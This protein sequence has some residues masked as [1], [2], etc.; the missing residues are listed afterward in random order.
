EFKNILDPVN[1]NTLINEVN[2]KEDLYWGP[3][4]NDA[5]DFYVIPNEAYSAFGDFEFFSNKIVTIAPQTGFHRLHGVLLCS[6][7]HFLPGTILERA[8]IVD[9]TPIILWSM[10]LP[11]PSDLDGT[12]PVK[13]ITSKA[14]PVKTVAVSTPQTTRSDYSLSTNEEEAITKRL[15]ELGYL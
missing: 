1:N 9:V 4:L 11:L 3:C 12:I 13:A 7:Q 5:P 6:G 15:Q 10:G 14:P 8:S 2:T